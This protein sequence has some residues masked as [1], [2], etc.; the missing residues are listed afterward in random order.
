MENEELPT[1]ISP[2]RGKYKTFS[3]L[4]CLDERNPEVQ[5]MLKPIPANERFDFLEQHKSGSVDMRMLRKTNGSLGFFAN[6]GNASSLDKLIHKLFDDDEYPISFED[7]NGYSY[8]NPASTK[9][10]NNPNLD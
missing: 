2:T 5:E 1:A 4:F 7:H 9:T 8:K 6:Q 10:V 3:L